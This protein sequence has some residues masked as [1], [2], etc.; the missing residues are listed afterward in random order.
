MNGPTG[1]Q[2]NG[3]TGERA[4]GPTGEQAN[5]P[6]G[7]E[8]QVVAA[9][10]ASA[11]LGAASRVL[12]AVWNAAAQSGTGASCERAI[13][14]WRGLSM[15]ERRLATGI[16]LVVAA[17]THVVLVATGDIQAGWLW[18]V[19]PAAAVSVAIAVLMSRPA[20]GG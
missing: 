1:E 10:E 14:A 16:V 11:I 5:G 20:T 15:R 17:A 8:P 12:A 4:D 2:A 3:P 9:L 18:L 7:D 19:A 13:G 6:P